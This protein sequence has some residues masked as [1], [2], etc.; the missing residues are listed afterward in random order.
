MWDN[1]TISVIFPTYNEKDS[2]YEAIEDFFQAGWIDEIVVVNNNAAPGTSEE[3]AR[4]KAVEVME[5]RQGYGYAIRCGFDKAKGDIIIISEPDG[6]FMGEDVLK[7]LAYSSQFDVVLGTR[8]S[9]GLIW[10]GANMG[11]FLKWGNI[12]VAKMIE[13]I[14]FSP[15]Q[16]TDAGCTMRLIKRNA[17]EKI[18]DKLQVGGSHFGPEMI[19]QTILNRIPF[20]E[21][22]LNYKKRI[23]HSSVT[24]N[25]FKAFIL[26][27]QMIILVFKMRLKYLIRQ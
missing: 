8:T 27:C 15:A 24:G 1:Q 3:V 18:K 21:I 25:P 13:L 5:T 23:G 11:V 2:I 22:P 14:F 16:L 17:L 6:T 19:I 7:L 4:T 26:G 10:E 20:V 9:K 12:F